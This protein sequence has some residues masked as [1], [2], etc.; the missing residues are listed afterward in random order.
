MAATSC[1]ETEID[2]IAMMTSPMEA[3]RLLTETDAAEL[4]TEPLSA[5]TITTE[6][7]ECY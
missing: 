1:L 4:A 7:D 3:P 6:I 5:V 2:T